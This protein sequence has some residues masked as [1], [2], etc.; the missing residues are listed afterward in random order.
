MGGTSPE[1]PTARA[2]GLADLQLSAT[3]KMLSLSWAHVFVLK[4]HNRN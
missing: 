3:E 2:S 1:V 4:A